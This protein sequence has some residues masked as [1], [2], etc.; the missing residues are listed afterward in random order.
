MEKLKFRTISSNQE[1][2]LFLKKIENHTEVRLP[3][4]YATNG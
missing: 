3:L 2:N 4:N 1:T